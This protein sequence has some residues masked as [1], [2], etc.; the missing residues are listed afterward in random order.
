MSAKLPLILP[1]PSVADI[2]V[3]KLFCDMYAVARQFD[4]AITELRGNSYA[5]AS[6]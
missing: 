3:N 5:L 4:F 1:K 6:N 2:R